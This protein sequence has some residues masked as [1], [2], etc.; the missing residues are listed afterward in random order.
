MYNNF[1]EYLTQMAV[2][3]RAHASGRCVALVKP[4]ETALHRSR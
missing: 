2:A 1:T 3:F 4:V